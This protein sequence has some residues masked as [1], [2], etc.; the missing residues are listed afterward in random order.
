MTSLHYLVSFAIAI[1]VLVLVH[2]FGHY[3]AARWVGV[4]VLRFSFGFGRLLYSKVAGKDRTEWAV[5]LI[6]LGGY[7][8]ML[9]EREGNVLPSEMSRAFN[10]QTVWRRCLIVLAGPVANLLLAVLIYWGIAFSGMSDFP[11]VLGRVSV[12]SVAGRAG[13]TEGDQVVGVDG[14]S[15]TGWSELKWFILDRALDKRTLQIDVIRGGVTITGLPLD[16]AEIEIDERAPDVFQQLGIAPPQPKLSPVVGVVQPGSPA[17]RA[18]FLSGDVIRRVNGEHISYWHELVARVVVAPD[19][20]LMV[21]VERAGRALALTVVPESIPGKPQRGR[22]GVQV[23]ADSEAV[24]SMAAVEVSYDLTQGLRYALNRTWDTAAFSLKVMWRMVTGSVSLRNVSGPVTIADYAGQSAGIGI[25]AYLSFLAL[26]SISIGV[27]NLLPI[28]ILDG[29]H[30]LYYVAEI[31]R[32]K[33]LPERVEE[34][35]QKLGLIFLAGLM[36]LAVF[37]DLNRIFF[38]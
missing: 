32:G 19:K 5:G 11:S 35:G 24:R 2:E 18:G 7:V 15:I 6:P 20:P 26:V 31:L 9:D 8:K 36:S 1:G 29:G 38:G 17:E 10:R 30:L 12:D 22:I 21:D 23:R 33:P 27:L 4:R 34:Y 25:E 13:L 28:P 16:L 14:E 3:L 37:N